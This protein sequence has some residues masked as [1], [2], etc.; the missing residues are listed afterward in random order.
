MS[1]SPFSLIS[2][3]D[4]SNGFLGDCI[5]AG[6]HGLRTV[7]K[8]ISKAG[9]GRLFNYCIS[10]AFENRYQGW[11]WAWTLA[12]LGADLV[13]TS[14]DRVRLFDLLGRWQIVANWQTNCLL[15]VA[16]LISNEQK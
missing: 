11:D 13:T 6:S 14:D 9:Q 16:I 7:S 2:L 8:N 1:H 12:Q 15:G 5:E 10:E 3:A 4:D